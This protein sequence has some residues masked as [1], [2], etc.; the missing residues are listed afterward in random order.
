MTNIIKL[1]TWV[2]LMINSIFGLIFYEGTVIQHILYKSEFLTG[3]FVLVNFIFTHLLIII[4]FKEKFFRIISLGFLFILIFLISLIIVIA[5]PILLFYY[6][7]NFKKNSFLAATLT[8][9]SIIGL[10]SL[11][12]LPFLKFIIAILREGNDRFWDGLINNT[13]NKALY[14]K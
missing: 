8:F 3:S 9:L 7:F 4:F 1:L 14:K 12:I 10:L 2:F 13:I 11:T 5:I 6:I